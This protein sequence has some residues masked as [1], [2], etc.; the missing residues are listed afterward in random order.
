MSN[1]TTLRTRS[2]AA[3]DWTHQEHLILVNEITAVE[4]D[5]LNTFSSFQKW[6][7]IVENCHALGLNRSL[8][9]CKKKWNTLFDDYNELRN[10]DAEVYGAIEEFVRVRDGRGELGSDPDLDPGDELLVDVVAN[11][12]SVLPHAKKY[13]LK[14]MPKKHFLE[15]WGARRKSSKNVRKPNKSC[16]SEVKV[17]VECPKESVDVKSMKRE[18]N[19]EEVEKVTIEL[20]NSAEQIN[21]VLEAKLVEEVNCVLADIGSAK[22]T[23]AVDV[24]R[25]GDELITCL[26]N[27]THTIDQLRQILNSS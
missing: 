3:P 11:A 26:E 9:Q 13:K 6:Q 7:I 10:F 1:S 19:Q 24:R 25:Q 8:N 27:Y 15:G 12:H 18:N 5:C 17:E 14:S 22:T 20:L 2:Q 16:R 21:V 4:R 23:Q